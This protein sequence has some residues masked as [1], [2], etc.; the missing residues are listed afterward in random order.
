MYSDASN[1]AAQR[2]RKNA[3]MVAL[4]IY[5]PRALR[6]YYK[7]QA[8]FHGQSLRQ[9]VLDALNATDTLDT[10]CDVPSHWQHPRPDER[11]EEPEQHQEEIEPEQQYRETRTL[12][13]WDLY[14]LLK[15][16]GWYGFD[17]GHPHSHYPNLLINVGKR[18][19]DGRSLTTADII[20][21]A[22]DILD[23]SNVSSDVTVKDIAAEVAQITRSRFSALPEVLIP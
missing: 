1:R 8:A 12:S 9:Y 21:I 6:K 4:S 20:D 11:Q 15:R 18:Q 13:A 16:K 7:A 10:T 3:D 2:W 23:H 19:L 22:Q 5:V 17:R 14:P